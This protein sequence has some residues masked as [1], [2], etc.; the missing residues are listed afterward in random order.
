MAWVDQSIL[1]GD[2]STISMVG[3]SYTGWT[4]TEHVTFNPPP[5]NLPG[6]I[7]RPIS[8][9]YLAALVDVARACLRVD[10]GLPFLFVPEAVQDRFFPDTPGAGIGAFDPDQ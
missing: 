3:T 5:P 8:R 10:G 2:I 6:L 1:V 9:D 7:W 4:M